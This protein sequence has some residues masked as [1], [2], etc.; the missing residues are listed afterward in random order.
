MDACRQRPTVAPNPSKAYKNE[1]FLNGPRARLLR[2]TC[3]FEEPRCRLAEHGVDNIVMI[4]GSARSK[5]PEE[6]QKA[7]LDLRQKAT[8]DP[9]VRPQ[10]DRLER[11][12][13]LC[14]YHDET[15]KLAGMITKFSL[16][17]EKKGLPKYTVGTGAGPGMMEAANEGAWRAG[18]QS[19]GFGISL[20]FEKGLNPYV[21]PEL[22]FEFHYFFT[23]KFWMA[24]KCMGLVVA[25]GGFGT[26]D[27]LFEFLTLV[28]NR[29]I[30]RNLPV[31]LF[32]AEY[33]GQVL[34]LDVL[35]KYGLI[36]GKEE[37]MLI[38][39]DTAE[40]AFAHLKKFWT[41]EEETHKMLSPS[42]RNIYVSP[43]V[44]LAPEPSSM[45]AE[46]DLG[47]PLGKKLKLSEGCSALVPDRPQPPKAYKNDDFIRSHHCRTFRIQCEFEET[48]HRL[49]AQGIKNVLM[50]VAS[51]SV[52]THE[53]HLKAV[54][55]AIGDPVNGPTTLERL[56]RQ[57]P[58]LQYHAVARDLCRF[59]TAWS[60][61]RM[62]EGKAPYHV[63]TGGGPGLMQSANE[64]AWE[65]GGKS[66]GL[67]RGSA[68]YA[69]FNPYVTPELAFMFHYFFTRKFWM[70]YKTMGLVALPGGWGTCDEVFEVLTLMQTGKIKQ[71]IPVVFVGK[72]FW[73][74][75]IQ[76]RRMAEYGMISDHDVD[77][78]IFTDSAEEAFQHI[79]TWWERHEVDGHPVCPKKL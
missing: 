1:A 22:G 62:T 78:L 17:N 19:V 38:T 34:K 37:H 51:G 21:T 60:M 76:W 45:P 29:T 71:K 20:P 55:K 53:A 40:D 35:T 39:C 74:E 10:L 70:A 68:W 3:E 69:D 15:I 28:K 24:Y 49:E 7:L 52:M 36:S 13:F 2:I 41:H 58:L 25:P 26:C 59:I 72:Q 44:R 48:Y 8:L 14:R 32:G 23:R 43:T 77:Q 47:E 12:Q 4:F 6:Y 66:I 16:E 18:G 46:L 75:V 61:K 73:Q 65:A 63:A 27:E 79:V 30:K 64:G 57:E 67:S 42:K 31:I 54:N 9:S 33:W 5:N 50:V 56:R 11:M